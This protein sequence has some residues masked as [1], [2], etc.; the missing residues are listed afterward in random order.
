VIFLL[1]KKILNGC[2]FFTVIILWLLSVLYIL[3]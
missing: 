3:L 1:F 2:G